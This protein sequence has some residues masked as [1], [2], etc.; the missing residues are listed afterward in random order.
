MTG[1]EE[2]IQE[3]EQYLNIIIR[4][5]DFIVNTLVGEQGTEIGASPC[6]IDLSKYDFSSSIE[7]RR[8]IESLLVDIRRFLDKVIVTYCEIKYQ[9]SP[10]DERFIS[11]PFTKDQLSLD[12]RIKEMNL[13]ILFQRSKLYEFIVSIQRY[14]ND[15]VQLI[16]TV[17]YLN[18]V[19]RASHRRVTKIDLK[20]EFIFDFGGIRF[21][22]GMT[23]MDCVFYNTDGQGILHKVEDLG[24]KKYKLEYTSFGN[25]HP[26]LLFNVTISYKDK[27]VVAFLRDAQ[28]LAQNSLQYMKES[29]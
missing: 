11:F 22:P 4:D 28:T 14:A 3:L 1:E 23:I 16:K 20:T 29:L 6:V 12:K 27:E 15:D 5:I 13:P 2:K 25:F 26:H 24:N 10:E 18:E 17:D 19:Y 7:G 21:S 8:K 9:I